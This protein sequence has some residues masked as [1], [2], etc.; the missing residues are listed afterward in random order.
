MARHAPR[1]TGTVEPKPCQW[2][3][4]RPAS[5]FYLAV[6]LSCFPTAL[7]FP[8]ILLQRH[9]NACELAHS[10]IAGLPHQI[11]RRTTLLPVARWPRC[12]ERKRPSKPGSAGAQAAAG[13]RPLSFQTA[14]RRAIAADRCRFA[15]A[16][17]A[18]MSLPITGA[19]LS[20]IGLGLSRQWTAGEMLFVASRSRVVGCK[21]AR[22]AIPVVQFAKVRS[23]RKNVVAGI[24]GI[25]AEVVPQAQIR[26]RL[27]HD[28]HQPHG[29]FR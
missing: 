8:P 2:L 7:A 12:R 15:T 1:P 4:D 29:A 6:L 21:E 13:H 18:A 5:P 27:R 16:F 28:L 17:E 11:S 10:V 19:S 3:A 9:A 25:V 14:Q 26:P 20:Q 22:R 24:V 23:A